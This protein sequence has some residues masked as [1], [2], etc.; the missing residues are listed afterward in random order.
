MRSWLQEYYRLEV[1]EKVRTEWAHKLCETHAEKVRTAWRKWH[2]EKHGVEADWR[3]RKVLRDIPLEVV[4]EAIY[5]TLLPKNLLPAPNQKRKKEMWDEM[6]RYMG[7]DCFSTA[8]LFPILKEKMDEESPRLWRA[9][10]YF[11]IPASYALAQ[12]EYQGAP[13]DIPYL[14]KMKCEV[15][16]LLEVEGKELHKAVVKLT[17]WQPKKEGEKFNAN[18]STQVQQVLYS[19]EVG[20]GLKMPQNVGRFA[21]KR[22][23]DDVT[24]NSDTLKVLARQVMPKRP[25]VA[26]LIS[27]ILSYRNKSKIIGTYVDGILDRVDEDGRVRGDFIIP[28]TATARISCQNPN[29]QN[30]PDASHVGYDIRSAY[31][32]TKGWT[33]LE[34]DYSQLELRVAGLFS[35]DHVLI[36]AYKNGADIHQEVAFM[37]WNKPKDQITKYERYLAKCMNFGVIYGRGA[38]SIATGPEMDNLVEMSGRSWGNKEI[39]AYFAKFKVGY[40]DLFDWMQLVKIDSLE[41]QYVENPTGHR[42]RFDLVLPRER[43]RVERQAVNSPIQGFAA[44]MTIHALSELDKVFD[45]EKQRILFTVHDSILCECLKDK[46][47]VKE[48]KELIKQIME[49]H[50]PEAFMTLPCLE[51]SPLTEGDRLVYNLPFVA[52]VSVGKNWGECH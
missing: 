8:R 11:D 47:T 51:H 35:Q 50:L 27:Q 23:E 14:K 15:E 19:K 37:L 12:V 36:E 44:R 6:M 22:D 49:T 25:A 7:E 40:K 21:Y 32:P 48:T 3:G 30:I 46:K 1:G 39:D 38:R 13:V 31:I 43:S 5:A 18:S 42:R 9:H 17:A 33:L 16:A 10:K 34:A 20:L 26:K 52:D 24:T 45:P 29:L 28:G 41:K 4:K 2:I